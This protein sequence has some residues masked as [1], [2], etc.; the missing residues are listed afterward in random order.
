[1][2]AL[3]V[4]LFLILNP[5][6]T[7]GESPKSIHG[8]WQFDVERTMTE[9][10]D[11]VAKKLPLGGD[12]QLIEQMKASISLN[13]ENLNHQM[14]V[15]FTEDSFTSYSETGSV[16]PLP[17]KVIGG[18]AGLVVIQYTDER[19]YEFFNSIRLVDGGIA[20]KTTDCQVYPE[21]CERKHQSRIEMKNEEYP[22]YNPSIIRDPPQSTRP[23]TG[24]QP[25][26]IYFTRVE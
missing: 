15:T 5:S 19:G 18:N 10:F 26:W 14:M 13:A 24:N 4:C 1:M 8:T 12:P 11:L 6:T 25:Q 21:Q 9:Y 16:G 3:A 17:Y 23:N 2:R 20:L 7:L 22:S